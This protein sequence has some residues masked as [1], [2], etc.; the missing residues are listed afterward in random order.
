[1]AHS[2]SFLEKIVRRIKFSISAFLYLWPNARP[3][4]FIQILSRF[5]SAI[6]HWINPGLNLDKMIF[7]KYEKKLG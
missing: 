1:M 2:G 5:N 7:N 6:I 4:R 3:C